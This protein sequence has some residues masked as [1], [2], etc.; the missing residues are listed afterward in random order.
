M[1]NRIISL[2]RKKKE[3]SGIK[4]LIQNFL[5]EDINSRMCSGK[6]DF[7]TR[8][9]ITKQKRFLSNSLKNLHAEFVKKYNCNISYNFFCLNRPFWIK[10]MKVTDRET[11]K[12]MRHANME[13]LINCL[14]KYNII[15]H[16][17]INNITNEFCCTIKTESCMERTCPNCI[18]SSIVYNDHT[19]MNAEYFQ[20]GGTKEEY[21]DKKSNEYKIANKMSKKK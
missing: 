6:K 11:C 9:K 21:L 18:N 8:L 2:N 5:E 19:P 14:H 4:S 7:V 3:D 16:N 10:E 15:N 1:R 13:L 17:S 12:C 20:W